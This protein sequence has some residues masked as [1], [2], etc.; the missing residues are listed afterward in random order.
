MPRA[1]P[2]MMTKPA[3]PSSR[4]RLLS[5]FQPGARCMARADDGDHRPHQG[6]QRAAHAEQRWRIVDT[7]KPRRIAGFL[8]RQQGN[9]ER[10]AGRQL[11]ARILLAAN[12]GL[13]R[14]PTAPRRS[15]SRAQSP[16]ARCRNDR[17]ANE[18]SAARH[19]SDRIS[20]S[21]SI[22][23]ASVSVLEVLTASTFAPCGSTMDQPARLGKGCHA[24]V[25]GL[26]R[27]IGRCYAFGPRNA[28]AR[29]GMKG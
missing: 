28:D 9:A 11:A 22:R 14:S 6:I 4:A 13:P 12:T 27:S 25:P 1:S 15:G 20:R 10:L 24:L 19:L 18:T 8:R 17:S 16:R 3:S 26:V 7:S 29:P 21:R 23:S 5:K 2:E